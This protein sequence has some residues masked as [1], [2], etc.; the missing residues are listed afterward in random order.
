MIVTPVRPGAAVASAGTVLSTRS[1]PVLVHDDHWDEGLLAM[2]P[3]GP[4]LLFLPLDLLPHDE[5]P[6]LGHGDRVEVGGVWTGRG[7]A[8]R[9]VDRRD[10]PPPLP[11]PASVARPRPQRAP[12]PPTELE[13]RLLA[14][15]TMTDRLPHGDGTLHVVADDVDTVTRLLSPLYGGRLRVHR[16]Q[17]SQQQRRVAA[18]ALDVAHALDV[19]CAFGS[20]PLDGS[21]PTENVHTLDV[22]WV[23]WALADALAP[24]PDGLVVLT[25]HVRVVAP[26]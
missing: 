8:V 19:V 20:A 14:D 23:P 21:G 1:G 4:D 9:T 10:V 7:I 11:A 12:G 25:S 16:A 26:G 22:G 24:V 15:G 17:F 18:A 6:V 5:A 13:R 2:P 3:H